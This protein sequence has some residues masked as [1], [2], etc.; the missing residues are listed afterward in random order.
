MFSNVVLKI[1]FSGCNLWSTDYIFKMPKKVLHENSFELFGLEAWQN[2]VRN[3]RN[4]NCKTCKSII[5]NWQERPKFCYTMCDFTRHISQ[6][7]QILDTSNG[8]GKSISIIRIQVTFGSN[9][10]N[11]L[12]QWVIRI[13]E[14][15]PVATLIPNSKNH[16]VT[17]KCKI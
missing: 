8:R 5:I 9:R 11:V 17:I 7:V 12:A 14:N 6:A 3:L 10:W 16:A 2:P 4:S 1:L 15:D 13:T